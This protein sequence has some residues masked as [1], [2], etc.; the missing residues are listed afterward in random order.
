MRG[1]L[2]EIVKAAV[3]NKVSQL[4]AR[5]LLGAIFIYSSFD[6]IMDPA[7]F[8]GQIASRHIV[9]LKISFLLA[10][11]LPWSELII[12]TFLIVGLYVR[13]TSSISIAML[14][15]FVA[16]TIYGAMTGY[17]GGCGCFPK[18]SMLE[19]SNPLL[20]VFRDMVFISIGMVII[21]GTY[22]KTGVNDA[23][24]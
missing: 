5:T 15:V 6:K 2:R 9:S 12:G 18:A 10:A 14:S 8:A 20:A 23:Q 17:K 13:E 22:R 7:L 3:T 4:S 1:K 19:T 24:R 21:Y 11:M 16:L